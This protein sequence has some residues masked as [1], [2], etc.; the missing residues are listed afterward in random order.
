MAATVRHFAPAGTASSAP[1]PLRPAAARAFSYPLGGRLAHVNPTV[2]GAATRLRTSIGRGEPSCGRTVFLL[3]PTPVHGEKTLCALA[4]AALMVCD[5]QGLSRVL[6]EGWGAGILPCWAPAARPGPWLP[7]STSEDLGSLVLAMALVPVSL[8]SRDLAPIADCRANLRVHKNT[9]HESPGER[10]M[11]RR[12][13]GPFAS[14]ATKTSTTRFAS[15]RGR[16]AR[17]RA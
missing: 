2:F 12:L 8:A 17:F 15:G 4:G 6:F 13:E 14:R 3:V 16:V 7:A 1:E 5:A 10:N 11:P 9:A